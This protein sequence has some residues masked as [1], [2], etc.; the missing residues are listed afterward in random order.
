[1][2]AASTR[3]S[4][5]DDV[6][7]R[8]EQG[9][10]GVGLELQVAVRVAR[11]LRAARVADDQLGA[12]VG[13]VLDPGRRHRMVHGRV[14]ADDDDD[15]GLG[16]RPSPGSTPRPSRC[17]RAAPP[18]D[19]AW[20][21]R[22]Q[23]STLLLPKAG[24]HQLLEQVGL[25]VAALGRAEAGQRLR[26]VRVADAARSLPPASSSASSQVA[27]RNTSITRSGSIVASPRLGTS[28][29]RI[30]GTRQALRMVRV[31]EAVAALDAQAPV[32]RRAVAALDVEDLVVLDV[33]GQ[34][35]A[36]A[37]V[38][39]DRFD[40][41]VGDRSATS[42]AGISA[43]V[44]Q[45]CT[46]SPQATQVESPIGS[47]MSKTIFACS[48]RK[49]RP[50][51]SLTCSSR[52]A[53][54]QR[55]HWMQ[56][57]RFTAI[58]GCD[59]SGATWRA[60]REARLADAQPGRPVV[61]LVVARVARPPACPTAAA[62]APCFCDL[63][64]ALAV[65]RDLHAVGRRAAA[66]RRQHALAVDLDHARAAVADLVEAGL[67]AKARDLDAFARRRSR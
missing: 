26:A 23:W 66:R 17:P 27:S 65:G 14:G 52:Q 13:R 58:A 8:V 60:R 55:V 37:A 39:A 40:L 62:R 33:V 46:H 24:A 38:R 50:M 5:D 11:Q 19:D 32:V 43:P 59:R 57:S 42:R 49:A 6:H 20:H 30:S 12:V 53:R 29:R 1:M 54:T 45:A 16:R 34:L 44:G 7:H 2:N 10:V 21:R 18:R 56:A 9:D 22:V 67:V 47:S 48:P 25:F 31:V 61:D 15:L 28:A 51:T 41:L 3:S 35:A 36:D 4:V 63:Q 64:R